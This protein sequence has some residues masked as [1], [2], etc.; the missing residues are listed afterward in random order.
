M[1]KL[2]LSLCGAFFLTSSINAQVPV[3]SLTYDLVKAYKASVSLTNK[4][5]GWAF[6]SYESGS[7]PDS[8]R[9]DYKGYETDSVSKSIGLPEECHVWVRNPRLIQTINDAGF[10]N[11]Q[12]DGRNLVVDGLTKGDKVIFKYTSEATDPAKMKMI[13]ATGTS[14]LTCAFIGTDTL[15]AGSSVIN[16][17]DT[18]LIDSAKFV[19]SKN[20]EDGYISVLLYKEMGVASI[21]IVKA[22]GTEELYDFTKAGKAVAMAN[23][24][25]NQGNEG[26]I[27]VNQGTGKEDRNRNDFKGYKSDSISTSLGLPEECHIF[28][29]QNR[30]V[31]GVTHRGIYVKGD[32]QWAVD[33]L[34]STD[35]VKVYYIAP[36]LPEAKQHILFTNGLSAKTKVFLNQNTD[37]LAALTPMESGDSLTVA[38]AKDVD[39]TGKVN[40]YITFQAYKGMYIQ[41]IVITKNSVALGIKS[42]NVTVKGDKKADEAWYTLQGI[43]V[44]QPAK[45]IYIHQGKK[46]VIR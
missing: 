34:D 25:R 4:N 17:G 14:G 20:V 43:R 27:Y 39:K 45:G 15:K 32:T 11:S 8:K 41:K 10:F 26:K 30:I 19:N 33:G 29:G 37:T 6:Y 16:S 35:V 28:Q 23:F 22:D 18:I 12:N 9:Q 44:A 2:L 24:N 13:Y 38:V 36:G 1:K 3:T 40:G 7:K 42:A 31:D 5:C 21:K 46:V